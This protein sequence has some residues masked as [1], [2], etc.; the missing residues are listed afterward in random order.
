MTKPKKKLPTGPINIPSKTL[1][2]AGKESSHADENKILV[3]KKPESIKPESTFIDSIKPESIIPLDDELP[4]NLQEKV[5]QDSSTLFSRKQDSRKQEKTKVDSGLTEV[6]YKKVAM[7]L[8][9]E[10]AA[11]LR[12]LK[13]TTGIPYEVIVDSF[14]RRWEVLPEELTNQILVEAKEERV[15]RLIAGQE[16]ATKTVRKKLEEI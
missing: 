1:V 8:S 13:M 3:N 16:K 6:A 15:R 11:K 5:I 14:I 12:T 7:R 9:E 2:A 10:S 4:S